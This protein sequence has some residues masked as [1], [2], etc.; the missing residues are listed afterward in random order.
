MNKNWYLHSW[1]KTIVVEALH[2]HHIHVPV[3]RLWGISEHG[4]KIIIG[5]TYGHGVIIVGPGSA[6]LREMRDVCLSKAPQLV[7]V[8]EHDRHRGQQQEP[9]GDYHPLYYVHD[10]DAR[11]RHTDLIQKKIGQLSTLL[12]SHSIQIQLLPTPFGGNWQ[13]LC[14]SKSTIYIPLLKDTTTDSQTDRTDKLTEENI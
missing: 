5:I 8:E 14:Y 10:A 2:A 12:K 11:V 7:P 3:D 6:V 1:E 13:A 9:H 4:V